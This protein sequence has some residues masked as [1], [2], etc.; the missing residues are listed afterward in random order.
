MH[1]VAMMFEIG[2]VAVT[3][4]SLV[5]DLRHPNMASTAEKVQQNNEVVATVVS[6]ATTVFAFGLTMIGAGDAVQ[7]L[8]AV[9]NR[10]SAAGQAVIGRISTSGSRVRPRVYPT[11]LRE[12]YNPP[13]WIPS[14]NLKPNED[15]IDH[16]CT[17]GQVTSIPASTT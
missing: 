8:R 12:D 16:L 1:V 15:T 11:S 5:S 4:A 3:L 9:G 7:G 13:V 6:L 10:I 2:I 17:H 14:Q